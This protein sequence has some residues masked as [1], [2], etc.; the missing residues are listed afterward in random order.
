MSFE[1][2]FL[3]RVQGHL[4]QVLELD[5]LRCLNTWPTFGIGNVSSRYPLCWLG[6][7]RQIGAMQTTESLDDFVDALRSYVARR[8][9][10]VA[11]GG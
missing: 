10:I 6:Q 7:D 4:Y 9:K 2:V 1:R 11:N 8:Q 3:L 5:K